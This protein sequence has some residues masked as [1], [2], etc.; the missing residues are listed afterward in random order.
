[1]S[2]AVSDQNIPS[3][4]PEKSVSYE[5]HRR[6]LE[7]RK[8]DQAEKEA[9]QQKLSELRQEGN[10]KSLV[11][12]REARLKALEEESRQYASKANQLEKTLEDAV[13]LN[14]FQ[15]KLGGKL[16]KSEYLGFVDTSRIP[17]DPETKTVDEKSLEQYAHEFSNKFKELISFDRSG[18][19]PHGAPGQTKQLSV[20]EWKKLPLKEKKARL[21]DV[22]N[23]K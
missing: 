13:K 18:T 15:S 7:Q 9:L 10:W 3:G 1:M 20:D 12:A 2:E 14:A 4:E 23:K 11:E 22:I 19:M 5:T 21:S 16:K 8:K 17:I 6:L